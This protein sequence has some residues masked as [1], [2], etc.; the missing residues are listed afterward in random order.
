MLHGGILATATGNQTVTTANEHIDEVWMDDVIRAREFKLVITPRF[1][2]SWEFVGHGDTYNKARVPNIET[3]SKTASNALNAYVYTDTK[4]QISIN[5]HIACAIKH[6]DIAQVLSRGDMK[7]EMQKKMGYSLARK[8]DVDI[9]ALAA[10]FSQ[11]VGTL[12]V[13][14]T[15]DNLL[16]AAQ[17]LEDAG[18]DMGGDD[19]A[20][21]FSPAQR[22]GLL[23]MDTFIHGSYVGDSAA[24]MAHEQATIGTFM[25]APVVIS[26]LVTAPA[27]GQHDN[28]LA[29]KKI[30]ALIMA[31]SASVS[32]DRIALDLADVVV[33]DEIYG[34]SEVDTY[35]EALGNITATDEGAVWL[36]GV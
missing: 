27:A 1:D 3:Q 2:R 7:A 6:E 9:A 5:N 34:L 30:I 28:F 35:S 26:P 32:T 15:Y 31:K 17:Y 25:G 11:N 14:L 36:K 19:V 23:K 13:E 33:E 18:V 20:W 8:L 10:S 12:G 22:A 24:R 21:F 4:Q 16:R 29:E